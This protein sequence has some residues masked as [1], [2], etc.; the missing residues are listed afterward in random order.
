MS[1]PTD[2]Y[3]PDPDSLAGSPPGFL[4]TIRSGLF[5]IISCYAAGAVGLFFLAF[6]AVPG[7]ELVAALALPPMLVALVTLV[8]GC[9][10]LSAK[11]PTSGHN[12][13]LSQITLLIS[14]AAQAILFIPVCV[15]IFRNPDAPPPE[16]LLA[17]TK[18]LTAI[19][20]ASLANVLASL[21]K[22]SP[23]LKTQS[24]GRTF[25]KAAWCS[26]IAAGVFWSVHAISPASASIPALIALIVIF[27][28]FFRFLGIM[29]RLIRDIGRLT[30]TQRRRPR[31]R[32]A[33]AK[34]TPTPP[35]ERD[36]L[37]LRYEPN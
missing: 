36:P 32:P 16:G 6:A 5:C 3:F 27:N 18:L 30:R 34:Q 29:F 33:P 11:D 1:Q 7:L 28:F 25:H 31:P 35:D 37:G 9:I 24:R 22:R 21:A 23:N 19:V 4:Q 15:I 17:I 2:P 26:V 12:P 13:R 8:I 10:L 20:T 14:I